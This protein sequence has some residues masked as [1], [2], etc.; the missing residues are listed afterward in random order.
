MDFLFQIDYSIFEFINQDIGNP[1]FDVFLVFMRNMYVWIPL[2][3]FLILFFVLNFKKKGILIIAIAGTTAGIADY[4]SS[5]II[6]PS[7]QRLRP[8]NDKNIDS[9]A[10]VNCGGGYSFPSSHATNHFALGIYFFLVFLGINRL[11]SY[12]FVLWAMIISFAQVYV[13][14]HYPLDVTAG[15]ILGVFIGMI[16]YK[17][18]RYLEARYFQNF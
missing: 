13:G 11:V 18:L 15:M 3:L 14:V 1:F 16:M 2:Y 10:R 5:S 17:L 8:C 7:V 6:K 12:A 4:T 9:I